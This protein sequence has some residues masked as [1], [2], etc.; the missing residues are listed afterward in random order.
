VAGETTDPVELDGTELLFDDFEDGNADGWLADMSDGDDLVGD[1][2]VVAGN[3]GFVYRQASVFG[4]AT[5][6]YTGDV[7]WSDVFVQADVAFLTTSDADD[8]VGEDGFVY[9]VVRRAVR[10]GS[11]D[12]FNYVVLE[13]RSDGQFRIR[14]RLD[15]SSGDPIA[16]WNRLGFQSMPGQWHHVGV[17]VAGDTITVYYNDFEVLDGVIP[18]GLEVGQIGIG[19]VDATIDVDN[20]VVSL[21]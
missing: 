9:F 11:D 20:V 5:Y 17:K 3:D 14:R 19:V 13:F 12:D 1:W 7:G 16:D 21:P 18:E 8:G 6:A 15:G 4:D 2:Q 10:A